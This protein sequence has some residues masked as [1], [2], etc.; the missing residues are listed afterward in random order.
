MPRRKRQPAD[1]IEIEP[2]VP[3]APRPI[4]PPVEPPPPPP[5]ADDS[6]APVRVRVK[7]R[8]KVRIEGNRFITI[9]RNDIYGGKM[10]EQLWKFAREFVEAVVDR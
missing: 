4:A 1:E 9:A 7:Q 8:A 10:A 5:P 3:E 2:R 6:V